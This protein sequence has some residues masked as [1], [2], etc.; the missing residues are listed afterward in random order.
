MIIT[1]KA[2]GFDN[3]FEQPYPYHA[4]FGNQGFLYN[5]AGTL[6]L[7]WESYDPTYSKLVGPVHPWMLSEPQR[8][9]IEQSLAPAP[10]GGRWRF[11][12]PPRCAR[13]HAPIGGSLASGEI[14]YLKY[15]GS[16]VLGAG[17]PDHTFESVL[18]VST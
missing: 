11:S 1:C 15:P 2:C 6:T 12:N 8:A 4:G 3:S 10:D 14:Y 7:V 18:C 17:P 16:V 9:T 5:D 13:C